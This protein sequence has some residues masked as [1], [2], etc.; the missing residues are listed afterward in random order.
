MS[1]L[2]QRTMTQL[3]DKTSK[4]FSMRSKLQNLEHII[5]VSFFKGHRG[6]TYLTRQ[7]FSC[8]LVLFPNF[9][10][11]PVIETMT[12]LKTVR[13]IHLTGVWSLG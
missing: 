13:R 3:T 10:D 12:V 11:R 5:W 2:L 8:I 9:S 1:I 4:V 7:N 6:I